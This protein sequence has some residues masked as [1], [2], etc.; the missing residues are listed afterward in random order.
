[1]IDGLPIGQVSAGAVLVLVVLMILTGRL[2]PRRNLDDVAHD[3]DQWRA[4]YLLAE[5]ARVAQEQQVS[6]LVEAS[7]TT[8]SLLQ[9]L[10]RHIAAETS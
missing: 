10:D 3:R 8:V 1:M 2:V 7:R 9:A 4:A 5:Q 6:E